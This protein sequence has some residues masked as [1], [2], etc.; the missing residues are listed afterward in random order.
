MTELTLVKTRLRAGVWEGVLSGGLGKG[1]APE[2]QVLHQETPLRDVS[3][4]ADTGTPGTWRVRIG[5]PPEALSDGVQ[6]FL[7][8]DPDGGDLLASFTI[9]TGEPLEDDIRG[10]LDLLRAELDMLKRAFRRHCLET[11]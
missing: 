11:M 6:T 3:V 2:L 7:I 5:I 8:N 1:E 10:E 9:V 4:V